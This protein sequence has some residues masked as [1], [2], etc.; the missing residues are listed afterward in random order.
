MNYAPRK[1]LTWFIFRV[2]KHIV[3]NKTM[4]LFEPSVL[5]LSKNHAQAL[6]SSQ[7]HGHRY[8]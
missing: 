6:H 2:G 5:I 4:N 1:P 3:K 8:I 7:D